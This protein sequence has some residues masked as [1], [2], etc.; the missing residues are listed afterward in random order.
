M[1]QD[2]DPRSFVEGGVGR[3]CSYVVV[4]NLGGVVLRP[5]QYLLS[6][7]I[8]GSTKSVGTTHKMF[9]YSEIT[10]V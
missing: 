1:R 9:R 6:E 3:W 2:K 8:E 10:K 7:I 4:I 5:A